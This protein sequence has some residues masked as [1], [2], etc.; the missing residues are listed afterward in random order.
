MNPSQQDAPP[1]HLSVVIP[2]LNERHNIPPLVARLTHAL[3]DF[4]WEVVF[5]DDDSSDGTGDV[6]SA[7]AARDRRVR[8]IRRIGRLGL[9]SACVE[10]I[11]STTAPYIVVMDGDLQHDETILPRMLTT[12]QRDG[13]DVVVASRNTA[14]G[15]MGAM[16]QRRT[17]L[18]NAGRWLSRLVTGCSM[19]DPMSGFFAVRRRF[20]DEV[21]YDLSQSGFKILL[22]LV[23]SS[24][25]PVKHAEVPYTFRGRAAG[26]SKLDTAVALDFLL[27]LA[28]KAVGT[29]VPIRYLL[30]CAVGLSG[31]LV[32]L[33]VLSIL[34]RIVL[35]GL[36]P[37]QTAATYLAMIW[38]FFL[39][40]S[41]TYKDRRLCGWHSI[42]KGLVFYILGCSFGVLANLGLT[43][44]LTDYRIPWLLAGLAGTL[45]SSVW[46]FAIA[47]V[48]TWKILRRRRT[49]RSQ[50][51][52]ARD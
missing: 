18:S 29:L 31:V 30:Y 11:L 47:S 33:A 6:C 40:N 5:I 20:F 10:G 42:S 12:L 21:V 43:Q 14:G 22:D 50:Q 2:V 48:L 49:L 8:L 36:L 32:H 27:L 15:S 34:H 24:R 45:V 44:L 7:L 23:A 9:S 1:P 16:P 28:D 25:R 3:K 38:N 4:D 26:D 41:I 13:L 46:N 17:R 37:A 35:I 51:A 52:A 19:S 39:N